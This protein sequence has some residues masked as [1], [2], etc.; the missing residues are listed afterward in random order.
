MD[1]KVVSHLLSFASKT[2]TFFLL[3][4]EFKELS[5]LNLLIRFL[6]H[7]LYSEFIHKELNNVV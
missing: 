6:R 2:L 1:F 3:C 7:L 5:S 4:L